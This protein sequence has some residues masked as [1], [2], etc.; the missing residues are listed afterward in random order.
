MNGRLR[1]GLLLAVAVLCGLAFYLTKQPR[2][3][4]TA[5]TPAPPKKLEAQ[6]IAQAEET[7]SKA[8][9]KQVSPTQAPTPSPPDAIGF[10]VDGDLAIAQGDIILGSVEDGEKVESG[11]YKP[12]RPRLW[13]S[14]EIPYHIDEKLPDPTR[15]REALDQLESQTALKFIPFSGQE[16]ALV[17]VRG[18]EHCYSYLGRIGGH[19]PVQLADSCTTPAI[20]H[21]VMHALGFIHE[22]S[23]I[24]RDE[25]VKINWENIDPKFRM[26]FETVPEILM[27]P[28]KG[29]PFDY[30]SIML[31]PPNAFAKDK[32]KVTIESTTG[33]PLNPADARLSNQDVERIA[34]LY[35]N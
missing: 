31:Y 16:D 12:F 17:F 30:A 2:N 3:P 32:A 4:N 29:T 6:S 34:R 15:V 10:V 26:Q 9:T 27:D 25:Y 7:K 20:L 22:H 13:D 33:T 5:I 8:N 23:R 24:D 11:Y 14:N 1:Q 18:N 21:E 19:Q 35:G 28:I